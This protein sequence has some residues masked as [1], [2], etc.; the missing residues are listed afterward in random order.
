MLKNLGAIILLSICTLSVYGQKID[1]ISVAATTKAIGLPFTNYLPYHPGLE[2]RATLRTKTTNKKTQRY[3]VNLG[4]FFHRRLQ[5]GFY[6][7]GEF[8]YTRKLFRQA[9]GL[10]LP[11]GVGYLH[12]FY[13]NELYEQTVNGDFEVVSQLGRPHAYINLGIGIS[14]L[15]PKKVQ[16]FIRQE[17]FVQTPFANGIPVVPH[18]FF[19]IGINL[20]LSS[21]DQ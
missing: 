9:I 20:K 5:T 14:Y 4:A 6:I 1:Q 11:I 17:L 19:K 8:Q 2:L 18:S 10:D 13:P 16:P 12:T 15:K 7:G 21:Y 3:N